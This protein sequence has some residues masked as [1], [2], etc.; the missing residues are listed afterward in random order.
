MMIV[1][2]DPMV[3]Q[4]HS[5]YLAKAGG[6]TVA[7]RVSDGEELHVHEL[8]YYVPE[9]QETWN[10]WVFEQWHKKQMKKC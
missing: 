10:V 3:M 7:A 4:I 5:N 9:D 8:N 1:E 2:N 6:F